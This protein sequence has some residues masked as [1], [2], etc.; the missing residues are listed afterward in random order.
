MAKPADSLANWDALSRHLSPACLR[1]AS[2]NVHGCVGADGRKD[3][4]RIAEVIAELQCDTVGLQEVDYRLDYIAMRLGMQAV[5]GLTLLRHD[6]PFGNALLTRRRV[7]AVRRLAFG[8]GRHEPRNALDVDLEVGGA[9]LRVIVTHLGLF[10]AERRYQ[11]RKLLALLRDSPRERI[12]V[13]GDMNEWLP[14]SRPLRWLN[15]ILG[16]SVAERSFPSRW[17]LFALDRVW[18]RPRHSLL[19]FQAHRS[20][21]AAAASDHLPVKAI[22][23]PGQLQ[24]GEARQALGRAPDR[25]RPRDRLNIAR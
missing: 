11:M 18:V 25:Q 5:P 16:A 24:S 19:A 14:L 3:A 15:G 13:L 17:P 4:S 9:P 6:G 22:V 23:A 1:I 2:Y 7:L 10:A 8:Y 12:I 21:L 20:M